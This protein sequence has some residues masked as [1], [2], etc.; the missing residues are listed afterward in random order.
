LAEEGLVLLRAFTCAICAAL[1]GSIAYSQNI[2]LGVNGT[3]V[4]GTCPAQPLAFGATA[5][6]PI[7]A[8]VTLANGDVYTVTGTMT[9]ANPNSQGLTFDDSVQVI[10]AGNGSGGSSQADKLTF[11]LYAA[12]QSATATGNFDALAFGLF[13]PTVATASSV[14]MCVASS[15]S[16]IANPPA[17]YSLSAPFSLAA[18]AGA[19]FWDVT[20]TL[21]FGAGSPVGSFILFSYPAVSVPVIRSSQG[22]ISAS[23]FGAFS[24]VAPGS[25]IEIYGTNLAAGTRS[26]GTLDFNGPN[27]PITLGGTSVSIE[28]MPAFVDYV[29]P[30]QVNAQVPSG[31]GTGTQ[32]LT[33]TTAAGASAAYLVNVAATSP[34]LLAPASFNI[35]GIP[36]VGALTIQGAYILP[37][38]AIAGVTTQRATPGETIVLYGVGFGSV[39]PN[40]P[41]GQIVGQ[42]NKLAASFSV[43]FG[44]TAAIVS[45][46]GL[47]PSA[48]GLYQ[49]NVVVP[50]V[51]PSDMT[52]LTFNLGGANGTQTLY[53]SV[54]N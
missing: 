44:S 2:G 40:I 53:I 17:P 47:A 15:C 20:L 12:F 50:N 36:Y 34:G 18:S 13:S 4:S 22:V 11:D 30:G 5:N 38:G 32:F 26:W 8:T 29:S 19:F 25:W 14:Q 6:L 45:F 39:T 7:A 43:S 48:V 28:G 46:E 35:A 33:V 21:N 24:T 51:A 16:G 52:P 42:T 54:G 41:A 27:A 10:Y 49:F 9:T 31:V 37:P 3:C 23:A 1:A